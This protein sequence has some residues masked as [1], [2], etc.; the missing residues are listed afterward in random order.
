MTID[1]IDNEIGHTLSNV[2]P[3]CIRCNYVRRD[4]P[5]EAW[6]CLVEGMREA[7]FRGLF[8]S[9]TAATHRRNC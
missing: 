2:V 7:V 9:W 1:R 8:G 3:A 5:H 4:M 6:L